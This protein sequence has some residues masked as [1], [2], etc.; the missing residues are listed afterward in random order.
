MILGIDTSSALTSAAVLDGA[1]VRAYAE[2][3][4]PRRHGEIL[5]V[6]IDQVLADGGHP[7]IELIACGVGPG[8]Y[9][10][11]RVGLATAVALGLAWQVPVHGVCSLDA[12]AAALA[13]TAHSAFVVASDARR[14]EVYWAQ[15]APDGNRTGGPFVGRAEDIDP[16]I[17]H[18]PWSGDGAALAGPAVAFTGD[19]TRVSAVEVA[20]LVQC[21]IGAGEPVGPVV[22]AL[23]A[24][25][26]D[27]GS[28]AAR[29]AG[30]RLL[31]PVPL[32]VRRPDTMGG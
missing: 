26:T 2:H 3:D 30:H 31:P 27:D 5:A 12:R 4:D 25:G 24:H 20:R 29:L 18:L 17:R 22:D 9:T 6:L 15:Y 19:A 7:P 1:E 11:L 16:G 8:P 23:A 28:T 32:Y 13:P 10:G 14:R 21:L